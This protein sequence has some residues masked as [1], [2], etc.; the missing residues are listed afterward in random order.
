MLLR[1]IVFFIV[2]LRFYLLEAYRAVISSNNGS[3]TF[4]YICLVHSFDNASYIVVIIVDTGIQIEQNE[5]AVLKDFSLY[6]RQIINK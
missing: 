2:Q 4:L 1:I 6:F 3:D 5:D